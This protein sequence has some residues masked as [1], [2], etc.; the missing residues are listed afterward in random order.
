[1]FP[2]RNVYPVAANARASCA[3]PPV[4]E[5]EGSIARVS[6]QIGNVASLRRKRP[7]AR[8]KAPPAYAPAAC[9]CCARAISQ[10]LVEGAATEQPAIVARRVMVRVFRVRRRWAAED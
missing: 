8:G 6:V 9:N 2:S 1:M 4:G 10:P 3:T 5:S 7:T